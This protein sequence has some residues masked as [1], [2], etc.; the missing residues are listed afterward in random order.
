MLRCG[1]IF[2][3]L[4]AISFGLAQEDALMMIEDTTAP[5][6]TY[7]DIDPDT[8]NVT[9]TSAVRD[10]K[11]SGFILDLTDQWQILLHLH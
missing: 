9:D 7:I 3:I 1:K 6:L 10:P 11:K 8:V 5:Q 2:T 4:F